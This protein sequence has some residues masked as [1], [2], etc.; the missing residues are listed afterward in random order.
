MDS[1]FDT[2]ARLLQVFGTGISL[3]GTLHALFR[4]SGHLDRMRDTLAEFAADIRDRMRPPTDQTLEAAS[5]INWVTDG[6]L[7]RESASVEVVYDE[8]LTI[9]ENFAEYAAKLQQLRTTLDGVR[10]HLDNI[11]T[12]VAQGDE[13]TE[14]RA[15]VHTATAIE[16]MADRLTAARNVNAMWDLRIAVAAAIIGMVGGVIAI[17]W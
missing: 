17:V 16:A 5:T 6:V 4:T 7:A 8:N 12:Y 10:D 2:L 11:R 14:Q 1:T 13:E 15:A 9:A 3:I